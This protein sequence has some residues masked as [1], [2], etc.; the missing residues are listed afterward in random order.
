MQ[1]VQEKL[2]TELDEKDRLYAEEM[3]KVKDTIERA[4][5]EFEEKS[6]AYRDALNRAEEKAKVEADK[7]AEAEAKPSRILGDSEMRVACE[8]CGKEDIPSNNLSRI[9]SGQL[10]CPTCL[11]AMREVFSR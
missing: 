8:C 1:E 4:K 7:R 3:A 9:D 5:A 6:Q 11:E 2:T 10:L